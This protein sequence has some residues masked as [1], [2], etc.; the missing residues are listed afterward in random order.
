MFSKKNDANRNFMPMEL[1]R[2]IVEYLD[3]PS[4]ESHDSLLNS[5]HTAKVMSFS[6]K[7]LM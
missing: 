6:L 2:I 7:V 5:A 1:K 3:A 4:D